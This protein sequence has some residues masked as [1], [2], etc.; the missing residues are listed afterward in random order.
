MDFARPHS[1]KKSIVSTSNIRVVDAEEPHASEDH[2]KAVTSRE[3]LNQMV[4]RASNQATRDLILASYPVELRDDRLA[5][6]SLYTERSIP[7]KEIIQVGDLVVIMESFDRLT[8]AYIEEKGIYSNRHGHFSHK[9]FIGKPFG[10]KSQI[11]FQ[12]YLRPNMTVV[13]SGTGSGAMSH[14]I[15]R[16]IAPHG[17]LHTYEFNKMRADTARNE[18]EKNGVNHLV[19]VHHRDVCAKIEAEAGFD[20]P[21]RS[22]DAVFLDLPEPWHAVPHAAKVLKPNARIASYSPCVE[23]TQRTVEA[24]KKAGFHSM[25]TM[26]YRLQ[27]HYVDEIEY[28]SPPKAKRPKFEAHDNEARIMSASAAG[29]ASG[30]GEQSDDLSDEVETGD[31]GELAGDEMGEGNEIKAKMVV[32]RP[33]ASMRGHSAFLTF[34]TAGLHA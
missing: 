7:R 28:K 11:I 15:L 33:F 25:K 16:T 14:A 29:S 31:D 30:N 34:A 22:V 32:A 26:E 19:T 10:S 6:A 1:I 24:M 12:L 8:F 17:K 13:E 23:Q 2:Q 3:E 5:D 18:F 27:E 21:P 9:D 4:V 20:L